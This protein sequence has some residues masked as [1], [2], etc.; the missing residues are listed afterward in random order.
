MLRTV[1]GTLA[2]AVVVAAFGDRVVTDATSAVAALDTEYQAAV[3]NGDAAAIARLLPDTFMLVTGSGKTHTKADILDEA[4]SGRIKYSVQDDTD[5]S[6]RVW[7][8][9]AVITAKLHLKG[10]D[11]GKP[12]DYV[13]WFSDTYVRTG[14]TWRY[15]F[16]QASLPLPSSAAT[17]A[18]AASGPSG[19]DRDADRKA[20]VAIEHEWLNTYDAATL[21]RILARDFLHPVASGQF[22][23]KQQHIDWT[24]AHPPPPTRKARF[25]RLDVRLFGDVAI[26]NGVVVTEGVAPAPTRSIFT[27]VFVERDGRWQ[28]VNAQEN[29]VRGQS[30]R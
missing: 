10:T 2:C 19:G 23:T 9:T 27:D 13:L 8:D 24:V 11:T 15:V 17:A 5:Q 4:R 20:I 22:L 1:F 21:D 16:G 6:V 25:E 18:T 29:E 26:A 7:G 12:F 30:G 28:A 3:K 14:N